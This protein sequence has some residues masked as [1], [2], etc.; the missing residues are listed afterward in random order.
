M[1]VDDFSAFAGQEHMFFGLS[2][3]YA[4]IRDEAESTL[5]K[6]VPDTILESIAT[7]DKP[8]FLTI[9]RKT[10]DPNK[11]V[12]SW[13]AFCVRATLSLSYNA[14]GSRESMPTTITFMFG[15]V[16][17]R[18]RELCRTFFDVNADAEPC[19]SDELFE[20]RFLAF[21]REHDGAK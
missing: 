15:R 20:R 16:D 4:M 5:R 13:F 21:R 17:E 3:P 12:V 2:D 19:F 1:A 18:G 10:D 11:V 9:G 14:G 6:Q 7:F 8:K